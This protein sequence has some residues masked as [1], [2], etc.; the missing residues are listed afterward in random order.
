MDDSGSTKTYST[1]HLGNEIDREL[2]RLAQQAEA[3]EAERAREELQDRHR[4]VLERARFQGLTERQLGQTFERAVSGFQPRSHHAF[5][6]YLR[7]QVRDAVRKANGEATP[8]P[9]TRLRQNRFLQVRIARLDL[10]DDLGRSPTV[11]E[12]AEHLGYTKEQVLDALAVRSAERVRTTM[13]AAH[14]AEDDA[15]AARLGVAIDELD[16]LTRVILDRVHREGR[17]RSVV[18]EELDISSFDVL[19]LENRGMKHLARAA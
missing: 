11:D 5:G 13:L 4:G 19:D 8:V 1:L 14:F 2:V 15:H 10:T 9:S 12:L 17:L 16:E 6:D 7:C 3:D 18:A